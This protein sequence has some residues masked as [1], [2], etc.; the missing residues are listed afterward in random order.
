MRIGTNAAAALALGALGLSILPRPVEE[1]I[2]AREF[3]LV[4][5]DGK[6]AVRLG[7]GPHGE[8]MLS[9]LDPRGTAR[10]RLELGLG[11]LGDP[12]VELSGAEA[13]GTESRV[14]LRLSID[15]DPGEPVVWLSRK[16][17]GATDAVDLRLGIGHDLKPSIVLSA[18]DSRRT[19]SIESPK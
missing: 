6:P 14:D 4:D 16:E 3:L 13:A 11:A 10:A 17:K 7:T 2:L 18:P 15:G 12:F 8:P 19:V 9:F 5:K 1:T